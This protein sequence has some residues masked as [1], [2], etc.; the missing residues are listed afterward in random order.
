[1]TNNLSAM[2]RFFNDSLGFDR[3]F[4]HFHTINRNT[5]NTSFPPYNVLESKDED[6]NKRIRIDFALAGWNQEEISISSGNNI[7]TVKGENHDK[8]WEDTGVVREPEFLHRGIAKRNFQWERAISDQLVVEDAT[9][10]G[11]ILSLDIIE[12][13][14]EHRRVREIPINNNNLLEAVA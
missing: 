2:D 8:E 14:P 7:L 1:M 9:F 4:D 6:G 13:V 12:L 5:I 3:L 10:E 11:G